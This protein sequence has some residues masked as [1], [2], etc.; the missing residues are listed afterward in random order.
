MKAPLLTIGIPTY[1]REENLRESLARICPQLTEDVKVVVRDNCSNYDV[2]RVIDEF[3]NF[4]IEYTRNSINIGADANIARIFEFCDTKWLWVIGDDDYIL[5]DAVERVLKFLKEN[6]DVIYIKF[7]SAYA[8]KTKGIGGF[9]EAMKPRTMFGRSYFTS[10]CIYNLTNN[11]EDIYWHYKYLSTMCAQIVRVMKHLIAHPE[12]EC[13]FLK[14]ELLD[15]HGLDNSWITTDL[16]VFQPT[17]FEIFYE[18]KSIFK[19]NVFRTIVS[20]SL[21][22]NQ[23]A[24]NLR[25]KVY[26]CRLLI[27]RMGFLN[28]IRYNLIQF[29][30]TSIYSVFGEDAYYKIKKATSRIWKDKDENV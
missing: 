29:I 3:N 1:N 20:T 5:P 13:L 15:V 17:L 26:Y 21:I 2:S 28:F 4:P 6:P 18:Q 9:A 23:N 27:F 25:K 19:S 11:K 7:H 16:L 24:L 22:Y 10:I 12:D 14:E 30:A 8:G